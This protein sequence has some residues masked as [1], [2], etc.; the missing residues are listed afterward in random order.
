[1]DAADPLIAAGRRLA[2]ARVAL[3]AAR[4]LPAWLRVSEEATA[5]Q[6]FWA[7]RAAFRAL[8]Q[9][10]VEP[11]VDVQAASVALWT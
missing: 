7:A 1:M 8:V 4:G 6:E 5:L 10:P 11:V 9:A 3:E 2:R